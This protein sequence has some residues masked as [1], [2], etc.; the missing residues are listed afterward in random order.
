MEP[1]S[2]ALSHVRTALCSLCMP[3]LRRNQNQDA[4]RVCG[5]A[6]GSERESSLAGCRLLGRTAAA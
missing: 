2:Q 1:G 6:P 5:G 4:R 3:A